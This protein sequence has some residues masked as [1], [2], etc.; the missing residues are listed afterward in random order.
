VARLF[1]GI[2]E[3]ILSNFIEFDAVN[4]NRKESL[5]SIHGTQNEYLG[6]RKA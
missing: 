5:S 6:K 2:Q 3:N 1:C 4:N